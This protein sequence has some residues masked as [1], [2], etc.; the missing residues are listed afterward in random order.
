PRACRNSRN[1]CARRARWRAS[2][3]GAPRLTGCPP[4]F[5][6][7]RLTAKGSTF[8][9]TAKRSTFPLEVS[10]G[11]REVQFASLE[12]LARSPDGIKY[13]ARFVHAPVAVRDLPAAR[14]K[15]RAFRKPGGMLHLVISHDSGHGFVR[16]TP[17]W[18]VQHA[19]DLD[20]K[21]Q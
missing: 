10:P 21:T 3:P 17:D 1:R 12:S 9:V 13:F 5:S 20:D 4:R 14:A 7:V 15:D 19:P 11:Q 6:F 16:R 8:L 2:L 18:R